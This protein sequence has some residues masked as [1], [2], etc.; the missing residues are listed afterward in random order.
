MRPPFSAA[1]RKAHCAHVL[2]SGHSDGTHAWLFDNSS[3]SLNLDPDIIGIDL[4]Y[5]LADS[6]C[7]TPALMYL[8]YRIEQA[9]EGERGMLFCDEGSHALA[10]DYFKGL[11]NDWSR[12]P[13]KKNN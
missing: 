7:K 13:R 12:T 4:T 9:I 2:M 10:D 5:L 1:K 3:D 6:A 8:T 11:I